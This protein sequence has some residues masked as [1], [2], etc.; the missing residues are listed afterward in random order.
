MANSTFS[1]QAPDNI[2][3][4]NILESPTSRLLQL[5]QVRHE[6]ESKWNKT[7]DGEKEKLEK[8]LI[9]ETERLVSLKKTLKKD[10][11]ERERKR[12]DMLKHQRE[13]QFFNE[14][15]KKLDEEV[16][17]GD[18]FAHLNLQLRE[19]EYKMRDLSDVTVSLNRYKDIGPPT[20]EALKNRVDDLKKARLSLDMTFADYT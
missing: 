16:A 11:N 13:T 10:E 3:N 5:R 20:N 1:I 14:K 7:F 4:V 18:C 19:L 2:S 15:L 9:D 12:S 17:A 8:L 6:I